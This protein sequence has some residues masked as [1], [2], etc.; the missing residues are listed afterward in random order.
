VA[1][2]A[3]TG[4]QLLSVLVCWACD[5]ADPAPGDAPADSTPPTDTAELSTA[6]TATTPVPIQRW[7]GGA[8]LPAGITLAGEAF[9][10]YTGYIT[11]LGGDATGD[12][13]RDVLVASGARSGGAAVSG[14][15]YVVPGPITADRSLADDA[16]RLY[17][18]EQPGEATP[19]LA[20][21]GDLD[22]DGWGDLAVGEPGS[23]TTGFLHVV[24]GPVTTT[25][26]LSERGEAWTGEAPSDG[27]GVDV[28]SAGD[29]TSDGRADVIVGAYRVSGPLTFSA[30]AAYVLA[31]P[32]AGPGSLG[33]AA[34]KLAGHVSG[35]SFGTAVAGGGDVDGDGVA[36]VLVGSDTA[37]GQA[38]GGV[39]VFR[40]PLSG[41][42]LASDADAR[43]F[44]HDSWNQPG[45][46]RGTIA[47]G[48]L[49]GDG[50]DDVIVGD[51]R[52]GL[53]AG[54]DRGGVYVV[55]APGVTGEVDLDDAP[56]ILTGTAMDE[57]AGA[58]VAAIGDTDGD[59]VGEVVVGAPGAQ[60][61]GFGSGRISVHYGPWSG[62]ADIAD[63]ASAWWDGAGL[64]W[65]VGYGLAGGADVTGDSAPDLLLGARGADGDVPDSGSVF[66]IPGVL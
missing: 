32:A 57:S 7:M 14:T 41:Q 56:A 22:G 52:D 12:G 59:G 3:S 26:P 18:V 35:M 48:D 54:E 34:C 28:A 39:Y 15:I 62:T 46:F 19:S 36:D 66:L 44:G 43:L 53:E 60:P 16:I 64:A 51:H 55:F 13:H 58:T 8:T 63:T 20:W 25:G 49:D 2:L 6:D 27:A 4:A 33:D 5:P 42:R 61:A 1:Y 37:G 10:D 40:G 38:H 45:R 23:T 24:R 50:R 17:G 31:G 29:V 9:G 21:L 30:G 11:A 47:W 65:W